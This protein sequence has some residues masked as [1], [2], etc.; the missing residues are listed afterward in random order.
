MSITWDV[1]Y[2]MINAVSGNGELTLRSHASMES[3]PHEFIC[4]LVKCQIFAKPQGY[5]ISIIS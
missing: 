4:A 1:S 3:Y 5:L 2:L